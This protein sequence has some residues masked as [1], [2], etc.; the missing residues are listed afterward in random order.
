MISPS[1]AVVE[2]GYHCDFIGSGLAASLQIGLD[3]L[4]YFKRL[5]GLLGRQITGVGLMRSD[6]PKRDNTDHQCV[7]ALL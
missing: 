6:A 7:L 5:L 2:E 4:L 3:L 1:F